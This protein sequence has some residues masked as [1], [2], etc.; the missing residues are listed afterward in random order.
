MGAIWHQPID[1]LPTQIKFTAEMG[2]KL[3]RHFG[4]SRDELGAHL[5]NHVVRVDLSFQCPVTE[6]GSIS[7]DWWGVGW[8]TKTEGYWPVDSPLAGSRSLSRFAWPNP[9]EADL[10]DEAKETV[11]R[12]GKEYFIVPNLGF[13]LFERAWSLRG[14]EAFLLDLGRDLV[15]VEELL[16]RVTE[17]QAALDRRVV[18]QGVDGRYIGE[19]YASPKDLLLPPRL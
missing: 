8:S 11:A 16:E 15:F 10:L 2:K 12:R 5:G 13:C 9:E 3:A 17:I 4:I 7:Y 19:A 6:D 18:E 1:R 14:F